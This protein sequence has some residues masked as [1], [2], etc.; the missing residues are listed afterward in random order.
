MMGNLTS[1]LAFPVKS[2]LIPSIL[3][4]T[5]ELW[6]GKGRE[7]KGALQWVKDI[8]RPPQKTPSYVCASWVHGKKEPSSEYIIKYIIKYTQYILLL[9]IW[10]VE[11]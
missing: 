6:L 4:A 10:F 1:F 8:N 3:G 11:N 9:N 7:K 5:L 2:A